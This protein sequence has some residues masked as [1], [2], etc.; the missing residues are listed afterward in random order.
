MN[1]SEGFYI[2]SKT[3]RNNLINYRLN[4]KCK[5]TTSSNK[6]FLEIAS[7]ITYIVSK[8]HSHLNGRNEKVL[9]IISQW[10]FIVM[11]KDVLDCL[12]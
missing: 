5:E 6:N 7:I 4:E 3:I 12:L 2:P 9:D 8:K 10:F 11:Q 1:H